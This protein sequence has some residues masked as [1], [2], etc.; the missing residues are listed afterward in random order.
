MSAKVYELIPREALPVFLTAFTKLG[1]QNLLQLE[2][3]VVSYSPISGRQTWIEVK[4]VM[5]RITPDYQEQIPK[6]FDKLTKLQ[7][8]KRIVVENPKLRTLMNHQIDFV[9]IVRGAG[10]DHSIRHE[11][12]AK[13]LY[14]YDQSIDGINALI[15]SLERQVNRRPERKGR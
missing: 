14:M 15:E 1:K 11:Q 5:K 6:Y 8:F 9:W 13:G 12:S 7:D 2:I 3:D 10:V 4:N